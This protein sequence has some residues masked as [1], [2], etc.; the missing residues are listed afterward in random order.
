M[1]CLVLGESKNS[2]QSQ[3]YE[4]IEEQVDES[5]KCENCSFKC[6]RMVTL[7]KHINTK[8]GDTHGDES[9]STFIFRLGLEDLAQ[10]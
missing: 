4:D 2:S 9:V 6:S 3:K 8:H 7:N 10:E 1:Q 5:F